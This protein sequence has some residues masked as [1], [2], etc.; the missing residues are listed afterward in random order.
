[1]QGA[2]DA[3]GTVLAAL[4]HKA[5][6]GDDP[7]PEPFVARLAAHLAVLRRSGVAALLDSAGPVPAEKRPG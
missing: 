1:M 3:S 4:A 6:F 5:V 7:W 2:G